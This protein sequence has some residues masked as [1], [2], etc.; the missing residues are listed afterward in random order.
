MESSF[1]YLRLCGAPHNAQI[2]CD[3]S[4]VVMIHENTSPYGPARASMAT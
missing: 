2:C 3:V 4:Y 1:D